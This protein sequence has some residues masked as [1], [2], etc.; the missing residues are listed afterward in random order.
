MWSRIY[1]EGKWGEVKC[2]DVKWRDLYEVEFILKL[3]EVTLS[4][5]M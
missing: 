5:V 1:F 2:S 4:I 3:S